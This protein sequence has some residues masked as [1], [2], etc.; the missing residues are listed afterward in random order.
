MYL[1]VLSA[2]RSFHNGGFAIWALRVT[3]PNVD[4]LSKVRTSH[5][6]SRGRGA[7]KGASGRKAAVVTLEPGPRS[8]RGPP[9][10]RAPP[11]DRPAG[12]PPRR[13]GCPRV[14]TQ[15]GSLACAAASRSRTSPCRSL[16][17]WSLAVRVMSLL[18]SHSILAYLSFVVD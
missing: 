1:C 7:A 13:P 16:A 6:E 2:L 18:A 10:G 3:R 5:P 17:Q 11:H 8:P 15:T 9:F 12:G 14:R 4:S